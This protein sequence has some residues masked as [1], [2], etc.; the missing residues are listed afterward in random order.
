VELLVVVPQ[1]GQVHREVFLDRRL[2]PP[3]SPSIPSGVVGEVLAEGR[4]V[5]RVRNLR[6]V[7]QPCS[8]GA[9]AGHPPLEQVP[10]RPP[11][12][13][14]DIRLRRRA[15]VG[16]PGEVLGVDLVMSGHAAV[17]GVPRLYEPEDHGPTANQSDSTTNDNA[18]S[19]T[20]LIGG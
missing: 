13:G 1:Q 5:I 14:S 2:S 12:C 10:R 16:A 15:P 9:H 20:T 7:G 17:E 19:V 11:R 8:P 18:S 4:K 6:P 3:P